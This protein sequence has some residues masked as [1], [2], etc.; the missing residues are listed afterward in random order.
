M[1]PARQQNMASARHCVIFL[2]SVVYVFDMPEKHMHMPVA[3][4]GLGEPEP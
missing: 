2:L 4:A 3:W 1:F